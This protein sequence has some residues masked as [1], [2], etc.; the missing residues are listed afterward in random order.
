MSASLS[1]HGDTNVVTREQLAALPAVISTET[2]KPVAH[3]DLITSIEKE[4]KRREIQIVREQ[5]SIG[6]EGHKMFGVMDLSLEGIEGARASLGL[7]TANDKTMS[8]Q[9][10]AGMNVFVCDNM[11]FRG[12][13]IALKRKHTSGLNLR[14]ELRRALDKYEQHFFTLKAEVEHLKGKELTDVEAK[15]MIHNVFMSKD[16]LP[17]RL[18]R[19]VSREYFA[20]EQRHEE[21]APRTAWSLHNAFTEVA[22]QMPLSTRMDAIQ[23]IG[24]YFGLVSSKQTN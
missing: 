14:D 4:L 16:S 5:F 3:I 8:L 18:Y 17:I 15:A 1:A 13:L 24:R 9:M 19:E 12:D 23:T 6:K 7:R 10:V 20:T 2:F 22:K 11:V 21:F